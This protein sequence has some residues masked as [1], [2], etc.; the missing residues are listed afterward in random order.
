M[1]TSL[2]KHSL[3]CWYVLLA[4][5]LILIHSL[6]VYF[7]FFALWFSMLLSWLKTWITHTNDLFIVHLSYIRWMISMTIVR[8]FFKFL[9]SKQIHNFNLYIWARGKEKPVFW[10]WKFPT[11]MK[12]IDILLLFI[13]GVHQPPSEVN[14]FRSPILLDGPERIV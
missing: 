2:M 11:Q 12:Y 3:W 13:N 1:I 8:L 6:K 7:D 14:S 10:S 9:S 5:L 4:F